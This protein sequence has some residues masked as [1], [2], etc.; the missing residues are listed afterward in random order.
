[1]NRVDTD[2]VRSVADG[3]RLGEELFLMGQRDLIG[4]LR[5]EMWTSGRL[6]SKVRDGQQSAGGSR[7]IPS[8]WDTLRRAGATVLARGLA[9]AVVVGAGRA[10][11]ST[12]PLPLRGNAS[13]STNTDGTMYAGSASP[14]C[15]RNTAWSGFAPSAGTT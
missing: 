11:R 5:D 13:S 7:S 15:S 1:M 14:T 2:A 8:N 12:L 10:C 4:A 3:D 9:D 6:V